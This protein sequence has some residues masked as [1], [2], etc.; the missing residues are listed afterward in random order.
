MDI[1]VIIPTYKPADYIW[2]CLGS[3]LRQTLPHERYE[4]II[5]LNG[6][7]EPYNSSLS[8]Y[9]AEHKGEMCCRLVQTDKGGVS[10]ARNIGIDL[11]QGRYIAFIDDD[12]WVSDNYLDHLLATVGEHGI[13]VT[14][15]CNIDDKTGRQLDDYLANVYH[16][17]ASAGSATLMT[18]RSFLSCCPCKIIPRDVIADSR[19]NVRFSQSEDALFMATISKS[20]KTIALCTA[21]TIYYRRTREGSARHTRSRLKAATDTI[22]TMT[23]FFRIYVSDRKHYS[24]PFFLTRVLGL[25][26]NFFRTH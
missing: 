15:V 10:N 21:D 25:V 11:A 7:N 4:V 8:K 1:S 17:N 13:A 16:R 22:A 18:G 2:Q 9:I 5:V 14:N 19:F 3:L 23:E 24:L 6:C 12:D 26:K 20:I